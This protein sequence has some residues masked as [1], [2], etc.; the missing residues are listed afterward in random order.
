MGIGFPFRFARLGDWWSRPEQFG[1]E[2]IEFSSVSVSN[3]ESGDV[4]RF[5][6]GPPGKLEF[7]LEF[8]LSH[9][10]EVDL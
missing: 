10:V 8:R 2:P 5:V 7:D 6:V 9:P 1:L 3:L 4:R